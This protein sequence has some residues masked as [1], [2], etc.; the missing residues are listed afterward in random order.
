[1]MMLLGCGSS[2]A[3]GPAANSAEAE[4]FFARLSTPPTPGGARE[5]AYNA[6]F[7]ELVAAGIFAK[8]DCLYLFAAADEATAFTNLIQTPFQAGRYQ[9]S[10]AST[11]TADV[12]F[13]GGSALKHITTNFNPSTASGAQYQRNS[14]SVFTWETDA[15]QRNSATIY[16]ESSIGTYITGVALYPKWSSGN[17]TTEINSSSG[18]SAANADNSAGLFVAV[19]EDN[20]NPAAST[21]AKL[22]RRT[23]AV[24]ET[25]IGTSSATSAAMANGLIGNWVPGTTAAMG[26]GAE[27][28]LAD[29]AN[30]WTAINN[31][32]TAL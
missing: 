10:G 23:S 4:A 1:M 18:F 21:S 15:T 19:R 29:R 27:L 16:I 31:Y 30:L 17:A 7:V 24:S 5:V 2:G 3:G 32:L 11:F 9:S 13:S 22:F 26:I 28:T 25:T 20:N 8:L 6:L 14:A 12:G